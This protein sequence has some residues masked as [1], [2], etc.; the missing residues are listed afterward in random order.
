MVR[1]GSVVYRAYLLFNA[2]QRSIMN[3]GGFIMV[4]GNQGP[5]GMGDAGTNNQDGNQADYPTY[6]SQFPENLRPQL[7]EY[8][9]PGDLGQA[10]V[11][12]KGRTENSIQLLGED[13]TEA[14]R[15]TFYSKLG[16]PDAPEKYRFDEIELPDGVPYD[17]DLESTFRKTAFEKGLS[18]DA[19]NAL[20][21]AYNEQRIAQYEA[22]NKAV[23]DYRSKAEGELKK[24]WGGDFDANM[25]LAKRGFNKAGELAGVKAEFAKF[26]EDSKLGNNPLFIKVFHAFGKAISDD[27]VSGITSESREPQ[28]RPTDSAGRPMLRFPSMEKRGG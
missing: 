2:E 12:L 1:A 28:E 25:E 24:E 11:D 7:A 9:S 18:Q 4:E 3:I 23:A 27:S 21:K 22:Y 19:A 10:L 5:E 13:A 17:S 16:R 6:L 8:Q 26:M 15:A 14:D 20:F